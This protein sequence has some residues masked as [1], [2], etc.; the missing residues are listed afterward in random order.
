M[1]RRRRRKNPGVLGFLDPVSIAAIGAG[2]AGLINLASTI[3]GGSQQE[4]ILK[5]RAKQ[6]ALAAQ[7]D[8]VAQLQAQGQLAE[9]QQAQRVYAAQRSSATAKTVLT[10]AIGGIA[11]VAVGFFIYKAVKARE[12]K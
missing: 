10:Y 2:G 1:A 5:E 6:E 8:Q 3:W 4:K 11:V 9:A 7:R 12:R